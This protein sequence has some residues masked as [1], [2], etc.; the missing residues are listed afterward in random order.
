MIFTIGHGV[1]LLT[2]YR[3]KEI[4][5]NNR[6]EFD[7]YGRHLNK[8]TSMNVNKNYPRSYCSFMRLNIHKHK[9]IPKMN[10]KYLNKTHESK[11]YAMN[12]SFL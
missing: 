8:K 1:L 11:E 12:P 2:F 7:H 5:S 4:E 6:Q 10:R 3:S 9:F